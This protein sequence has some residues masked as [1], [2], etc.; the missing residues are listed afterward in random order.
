MLLVKRL[1]KDDSEKGICGGRQDI[2]RQLKYDGVIPRPSRSNVGGM[3][4][5][6]ECYE[7]R[8]KRA[9]HRAVL[10]PFSHMIRW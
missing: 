6:F 9:L 2:E 4:E 5:A 3:L 8:C 10:L 1:I 7:N